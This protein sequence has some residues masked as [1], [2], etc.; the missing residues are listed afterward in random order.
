M[1]E[2]KQVKDRTIIDYM[3]RDYE[4]LL[5]SMQTQI[6]YLIPKWTDYRNEADFGNVLLQLFAHLGD[7]LSYYQDRIANESFLMTAQSRKSIIHHLSLIGYK[8]A[9]AAPATA[10]LTLTVPAGTTQIEINK[11]DAFTTTS[12]KDKNKPSVRFEYTGETRTIVA[13]GQKQCII[14]VEE[15]R[16]V[17][18]EIL[19]ISD[20]TPNQTFPLAHSPLILRN[21]STKKD[22]TLLVELGDANTKWQ[23]QPCFAFSQSQNHFVI[24]IDEDHLATV[25]FGDGD[26]FGNIPPCDS[27]IKATYRVGGGTHGNVPANTIKTIESQ[28]LP[29]SAKVTN[30]EPATGG[31]APEQIDH[32][33]QC[34]PG[35]F[36]SQQRAVTLEDYI[37]LARQFNG[38][39]KVDAKATGLNKVTLYVKP[40]GGWNVSDVLKRNLLHYFEDK[41]MVTT[42]VDIEDVAYREI[43]VTAQ[44]SVQPYYE[45][46]D[47]KAQFQQAAKQLFDPDK[48]KFG[49]R[50][51]LNQFYQLIEKVSGIEYV[52]I[53][54]FQFKSKIEDAKMES[55]H[56]G[57]IIL[58]INELPKFSDD[59]GYAGSIKVSLVGG[60]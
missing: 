15:G 37:Y 12:Q 53:T 29:K 40:T 44:L 36:R 41:R 30:P 45:P 33:I 49:Q 59:N 26:E 42:I 20:G 14:P 3:A 34:A 32:A 25:R 16:L 8:L 24:E 47:I 1:A 48:I 54:E 35:V 39:E 52:N 31:A 55:I 23:L 56:T 38:V 18:D 60:E 43:Y 58:N 22:I 50:I 11:G 2:I 5:Q 13:N 9:T 28:S 46:N 10:E 4:S 51:Y 7:I 17:Q 21:E 27:E 6:P 57:K 19:G